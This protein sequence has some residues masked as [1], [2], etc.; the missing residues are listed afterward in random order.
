[1]RNWTRRSASK[2]AA[3]AARGHRA[4]RVARLAV[5][6]A[7]MAVVAGIAWVTLYRSS[8]TAVTPLPAGVLEGVTADGDP[9]LG[10]PQ[11]PVTIDEF[12]D[13]QCPFCGEFARTTEPRI[14]TAYVVPGKVRIVWHTLAFIGPE[15]VSAGRAAWCAQAQGKFWTFFALLYGHQG[16]ENSGAFMPSRL[17]ALAGD[18]GLNVGAFRAC[19]G[20][21][22]SLAGVRAGTQV[23]RQRDVTV[24][25]TFFIDGHKVTGTLTFAQIAP[26]IDSALAGTR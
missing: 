11:A 20:S 19:L 7:L 26:L 3:P 23:A 18:A 25:P 6:A 22:Q 15:S 5:T 12:G 8:N 10:S 17:E 4:R 14:V 2:P 24:T 1:M 13:F 9:Y 21:E 16:A